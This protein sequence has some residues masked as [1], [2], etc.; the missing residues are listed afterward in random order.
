M[1]RYVGR[2]GRT[3]V[4]SAGASPNAVSG[5]SSSRRGRLGSGARGR[6]GRDVCGADPADDRVLVGRRWRRRS[7]G[8]RSLALAEAE[9]DHRDVV[10]AAALVRR[11]H[12]LVRDLVERAG[13]AQDR[14]H[15]VVRDHRREPVRA[16]QEHVALT[17]RERVGVH[18]HVRLRPKRAR[19]DRPLR[20]VLG[21]LRR[22]LAAAL[23]LGHQRVIARELLEL[24]VAQAVG[25][26]VAHV[27]EAHLVAVDLG[28]R[29]RGAHS[30]AR[31]VRHR[32]VVDAPVGLAHDVRQ[33]RLRRLTRL[34]GALHGLHGHGRRHLT[35][36]CPTHPVRHGE[37]RR[38]DDE[39]ILVGAALAADVRAA[40]LLDDAEGHG[41]RTTPR[42]G[43]RCRLCGSC[44]PS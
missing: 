28:Q 33:L 21:R 34:G 43:I 15:L 9:Q 38:I 29:E 22:D 1:W 7:R 41:Y 4:A 36:L 12:E 24:A 3:I 42:S 30:A 16:D 37:Q 44:R 31:L 14:A 10:L 25:A 2:G 23:Q 6:S 32:E 8:L 19:D 40:G 20:M 13:R 35:G 26:A 17:S 27:R 5:S 18:L 39:R 11:A